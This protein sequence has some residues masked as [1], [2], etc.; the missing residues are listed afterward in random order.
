MNIAIVTWDISI[1]GGTQR[2]ALELAN[3]LQ[4]KGHKVDFYTYY[5]CLENCYSNLCSNLNIKYIKYGD[6]PKLNL[7]EK[8]KKLILNN[9]EL[10]N[11]TDLLDLQK[12]NYDV[13]LVNDYVYSLSQKIKEQKIIW[14][15]NDIPRQFFLNKLNHPLKIIFKNINKI[16]IQKEIKNINKIIVLD[17]RVQSKMKQEYKVKTEVVRSGI[18]VNNYLNNDTKKDYYQKPIKIFASGI[19]YPHR[20]FEDIVNAIAILDSEIKN[21]IEVLINGR[22]ERNT[23]YYTY[24]KNLIDKNKL[25]NVIKISQGLSENKLKETYHKSHIFIF[26]NHQQTWG[27]A[28]F[29][30]MLAG[31]LCIVSDTTGAHEVLTNQENALIVK[32]KSPQSIALA[33]ENVIKNPQSM[34][35]IAENGKNFV[36]KNLSW[37]K[38]AQNMEEI[39]K[40]TYENRH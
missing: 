9:Q 3:K 19:F 30:A 29:E 35:V 14:M 5:Y 31:C 13:I 38:Y 34:G 36:L 28:V 1:K 25:N 21:N 7:I 37:E 23:K 10:Q 22:I 6:I 20:R 12:N 24:I 2:Q 27:L 8:I 33:L 40:S 4:M 32:A 26:P 11:L 16:I 39:I 15:L 17:K 18:D